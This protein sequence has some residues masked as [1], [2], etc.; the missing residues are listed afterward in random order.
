VEGSSFGLFFTPALPDFP[1]ADV[2]GKVLLLNHKDP[3]TS[4]FWKTVVLPKALL[5]ITSDA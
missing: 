2:L 4:L 5:L 3:Q 1:P